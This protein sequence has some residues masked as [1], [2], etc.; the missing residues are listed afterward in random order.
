MESTAHQMNSLDWN[1]PD[2]QGHFGPFGGR[3]VPE[4]LMHPLKEL[5]QEY[6]TAQVDP[7]FQQEL[8]ITS[9]SLSGDPPLST[10]LNA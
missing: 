4:T 6:F 5:E 3:Y 7:A 9:R 1:Q 8:S 10:L 2:A